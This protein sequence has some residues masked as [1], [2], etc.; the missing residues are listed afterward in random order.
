MLSGM[1]KVDPSER[2][3]IDDVFAHP[4]F[5]PAAKWAKPPLRRIRASL[6]LLDGLPPSYFD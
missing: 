1:L 4:L 6:D 2:F 5:K 3:T